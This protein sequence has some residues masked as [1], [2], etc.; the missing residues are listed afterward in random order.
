MSFTHLP[1]EQARHAEQLYETLKA[2]ADADLHKIAELLA[3]KPDHKLFGETEF[4][5]RKIVHKIG[6][7]ALQAAAERRK[8]GGIG[9]PA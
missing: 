1:E 5:L 4:Q 8:K 6:A 9:A 2:A 3:S 7:D